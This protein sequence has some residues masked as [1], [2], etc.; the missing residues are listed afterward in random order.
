M[1][2]KPSLTPHFESDFFNEPPQVSSLNFQ[3]L[4]WKRST[5]KGSKRLTH[6][7]IQPDTALK[8]I[9][10]TKKRWVM[11]WK[12]FWLV[13]VAFIN[14]LQT[15]GD[16]NKNKKINKKEYSPGFFLAASCTWIL[17][18]SARHGGSAGIKAKKKKSDDGQ[19][20]SLKLYLNQYSS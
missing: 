14:A 2:E 4:C 11:L 19:K 17:S 8:R 1:E 6:P 5:W 13:R 10:A 15:S 9:R 18:S 20:C 16:V 12:S 7:Y 3:G